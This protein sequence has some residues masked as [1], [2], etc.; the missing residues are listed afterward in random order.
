M[1]TSTSKQYTVKDLISR[2]QTCD[3]EAFIVTNQFGGD[4]SILGIVDVVRETNAVLLTES[5]EVVPY[6]TP[7]DL[8]D[9][10]VGNN[11][12]KMKIVEIFSS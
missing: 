7:E 2:L 5:E 12:R 11:D 6:K 3:P 10:E 9:I 1:S 8:A 4:M